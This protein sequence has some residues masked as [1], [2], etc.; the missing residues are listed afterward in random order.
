MKLSQLLVL[1]C[2][3]ACG[4][5]NTPA[6]KTPTVIGNVAFGAQTEQKRSDAPTSEMLPAEVP[7]GPYVLAFNS[8]YG[9]AGYGRGSWDT[10]TPLPLEDGSLAVLS[11]GRRVAV[12]GKMARIIDRGQNP[13]FDAMMQV[14]P[15]S[16]GGFLFV[17]NN[18]VRYAPR[19]DAEAIELAVRDFSQDLQVMFGGQSVLFADTQR[20]GEDDD[21]AENYTYVSL[22]NGRALSLGLLE[23]QQLVGTLDGRSA[24]LN[25]VGELYYS[26]QPGAAWHKIDVPRVHNLQAVGNEIQLYDD[27]GPYALDPT[28]TRAQMPPVSATQPQPQAPTLPPVNV[29]MLQARR[30]EENVLLF[31]QSEQL[32]VVDRLGNDSGQTYRIAGAP[33]AP[34]AQPTMWRSCTFVSDS[35][36][37]LLGCQGQRK[38]GEST[39][40]FHLFDPKARVSKLERGFSLSRDSG[41]LNL[42]ESMS[43]QVGYMGHCNGV[44]DGVTVCVRSS[45]GVYKDLDMRKVLT[46]TGLVQANVPAMYVR[47]AAMQQKLVVGDDGASAAV[48]G[49]TRGGRNEELVLALS[50]GRSR[51]IPAASLPKRLR[52]VRPSFYRQ[53]A[54]SDMWLTPEGIIGILAP[55]QVYMRHKE[56]RKHPAPRALAFRIPIAGEITATSFDGYIGQHGVRVLRMTADG[57]GFEESSD[58]GQTFRAVAAP[59]GMRDDPKYYTRDQQDF[60]AETVCKIGPWLRTGWGK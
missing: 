12:N 36:P 48:L 9:F 29:H 15:G 5:G 7:L 41:P 22:T 3:A 20:L 38:E 45:A 32:M 47:Y 25:Q 59:P 57:T 39:F 43:G 34:G 11:F 24:A 40:S 46:Q 2:V 50:D 60:C 56:G 53:G 58:A 1:L 37:F 23:V 51:T 18:T 49:T 35:G 54:G 19:F 21:R 27:S 17:V 10:A 16:G 33:L 28:Q 30:L 44:Q 52:T 26:A 42:A 14:P 8:R 31:A 55:A 4:G 6:A 13:Q